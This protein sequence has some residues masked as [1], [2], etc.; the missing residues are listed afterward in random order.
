MA[1]IYTIS[2]FTENSP[3]VLHRITVMFTRRK[4]NIESLTVS[5]TEV[6]GRSRFTIVVRCEPDLVL[7]IVKQLN[8][9]IEVVDVFASENRHLIFKEIAFYRVATETQ[10]KRLEVEEH[11]HRYGAQVGFAHADY[12]V[13][14]KTGTE[15]EISSLFRLL[16]PYGIKEFV[17][18]GRIAIPHHERTPGQYFIAS[19]D[20]D[21]GSPSSL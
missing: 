17:R 16:E 4:I 1:R 3:G 8:R 21:T 2:A 7:K 18:S 20:D 11:A 5:E 12:I 10:Q 15:M 6:P 9:I 14:E 19:D 13:V